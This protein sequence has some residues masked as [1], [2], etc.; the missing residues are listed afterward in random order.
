MYLKWGSLNLYLVPDKSHVFIIR[1]EV[2]SSQ[3]DLDLFHRHFDHAVSSGEHPVLRYQSAPADVTPGLL[4]LVIR[5]AI[6]QYRHL[7]KQC[8]RIMPSGFFVM[9][10]RTI[11]GYW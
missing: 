1:I 3:Q 10:E 5:G 8:K 7:D 11:Q 4:R 2:M 6:F 9:N